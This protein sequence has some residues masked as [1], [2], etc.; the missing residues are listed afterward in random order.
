MNNQ[1]GRKEVRYHN[2]SNEL[3]CAVRVALWNYKP[4]AVFGTR[5]SDPAL[6]VKTG[7]ITSTEIAAIVKSAATKAGHGPAR[8]STH[9]V[10]IGG[11]TVLLN[12][13]V[14][15]LVIKLMG[16][17]LSNA[18]EEYSVLSFKGSAELSRNMC[19]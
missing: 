16:R 1:F 6:S 3:I 12:T 7:G 4:A 13:G 10:Q 2:R 19:L 15:R 14:D 9:Y 11:A 17:W 18:F 5:A 8:F